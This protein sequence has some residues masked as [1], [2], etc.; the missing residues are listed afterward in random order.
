MTEDIKPATPARSA[1]HEA[2][3]RY[4]PLDMEGIDCCASRQAVHEV[5]DELDT[6]K[7]ENDRLREALGSEFNRGYLIACCNVAN[8]HGHPD[9]AADLMKASDITDDQ[10][11]SFDLTE[12]DQGAIKE[13]RKFA[14]TWKPVEDREYANG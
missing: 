9:I 14:R 10:I 4:S 7:A 1:A 11:K 13:M 12:Y 2:L 6:L 8:A 5:S 3:L